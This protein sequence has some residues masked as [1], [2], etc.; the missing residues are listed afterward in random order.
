MTTTPRHTRRTALLAALL[1][2]CAYIHAQTTATPPG[3][4]EDEVVMLS[5]FEV[6][7][8]DA[9]GGYS[10]T[11]TLAGNRLN[12]DLRDVGS[13]VTVLTRQFFRDTGAVN[14][15]S[16][17]QYAPN[18]EVG[19]IS[20]N[21]AGAG[22]G[23]R[24]IEPIQR[25]NENTR[26]R[27]LAAADN[28]RDFFRTDIPWDSYNVDRVDLQRGPNSIL[29]GQGSP[30][31]IINAGTKGAGFRNSG[32][33]E[34][35][36]GSFGSNRVSLD[37]NQ[38]LV[39][40]Q[41]ALRVEALHDDQKFK[42]EPAYSK[43]QRLSGALRIEPELLK[44][45]GNRTIFKAS[46]ETGKIDSNNPRALPPTDNIT[47][48]FT[49]GSR[50]MN[51]QQLIGWNAWDHLSGRP[52]HGAARGA[53]DFPDP[54]LAGNSSPWFHNGNFGTSAGRE[55]V[56]FFSGSGA[57]TYWITD[58]QAELQGHGIGPSGAI[59]GDIGGFAVA[60][61]AMRSIA[62]TSTW[63][64]NSALPYSAGG[65]FKDNLITDPSIFDF[66]NKLI[67]GDTKREWQRFNTVTLNLTQTF[68]NDQAG[69]SLDYN[70]EHYQSGTVAMLGGNVG[71]FV[72]P[73]KVFDDGTPDVGANPGVEPFS[74]G[75]PNPGL[76]RPFV[77]S[78]GGV[79]NSYTSDRE[80][81]RATGFV[82]HDFARERKNWL[83]R[84]VG[85]QTLTG[86]LA[87]DNQKTDNRNWN[88]YGYMDQSVYD[89]EQ[90]SA[91]SNTFAQMTP[92]Q[93]VY[94]GGSLLGK[95]IGGANI[96][97]V[98]GN[99][100]IGNGQ[101]RYFNDHW[102][103]PTDPTAAGYVDPAAAWINN[104]YTSATP[105]RY[106]ST[107]SENPANY[108]GWTSAPLNVTDSESAAGNREKL[109]TLAAL[110]K[111]VTTSQ[112]LV[113]QGKM[114]DGSIV[115]TYGWRKDINKSWATTRRVG[116]AATITD[117]NGSTIP[118]PDYKRIDFNHYDLPSTPD[119][120]VEVQSR[121]YSI[122]GH[123]MDLPGLKERTKRL[124]FEVSLSY[125]VSSNFKPDS[126]RVDVEGNSIASPS[127][128]TI[129]RGIQIE[130]RDG[131]Y[132]LKI[133][134]YETSNK[135]AT[136][137]NSGAFGFGL[138]NFMGYNA[139][140]TNVWDYHIGNGFWDNK[141]PG[142]FE[143]GPEPRYLFRTAGTEISTP[144]TVADQ[145]SSVAG[146]RAFEA[147]VDK[148]LPNF[149]KAW[150]FTNL[151]YVQS[152]SPIPNAVN[153]DVR[154]PNGF[155]VTEDSV[156]KGWEIE[157]NAQPTRNWRL[158]F[159]AS[160]SEAVRSNIGGEALNKLM[161]VII[162]D[163]Q[164]PAGQLHY[165]WGTADVPRAGAA[166]YTQLQQTGVDWASRK[167]LEGTNVPELREWRANLISNYEITTGRLNGINFGGG[168]RYQS[169]VTIGY[170]PTGDPTK[171]ATYGYDLANAYKGPT[172]TNLDLWVG[173][174]RKLTAK[175]DWHIQLNVRNAFKGDDLIPISV[176]G[177]ISGQPPGTPA[178]YRI[179]PVQTFT[180]TN[181]FDF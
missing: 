12:T 70:K 85:G 104:A 148:A 111:S 10:A 73:M 1:L 46:F 149:W 36:Y 145:L 16:L 132:S 2:P 62:T 65:I 22:D 108:V 172:E 117:T 43:D 37:I 47:P 77:S 68:L 178:G 89:I 179:A 91:A 84:I 110:T 160:K 23:S 175:I 165:W 57:P 79:N 164:G 147:N 159:N 71:L 103:R 66:Y 153:G 127:G 169:D 21:Y 81:K 116:T 176:Q 130:T 53:A 41:V 39:P 158:T 137:T 19:G 69:F 18:S 154:V 32:E 25:P 60:P 140:W 20:G 173:Y 143:T 161:N 88:R 15:A 63:A 24:L 105:A 174:R 17:L 166:L 78:T 67:D 98:S 8:N 83:G 28:T 92:T 7:S 106:N 162:H 119:G 146:M 4:Q 101:L 74:N 75:T 113:W 136:G 170:P 13:A 141:T 48:W 131:K 177:P 55:P 150:G 30:A 126:S 58:V 76:G 9:A 40:S 168:V 99:P 125:N 133:N 151:A 102:N 50:G 54:S 97:N 134:R 129:D 61:G 38:V 87:E 107:Q 49:T 114:F 144:E 155:A 45:N 121:S 56:A 29:F 142:Y 152:G 3:T 112:A 72:D 120:R 14:N 11:T 94:L 123:L 27:G 31:G 100:T 82:T 96:P 64:V 59:D 124:P 35:R 122:V 157:L 115:G 52:G 95:S 51:Q 128:R 138:G 109:T 86:L 139:L 180:L 181:T 163:M 42:Q 44:K 167:L 5:P 26:I 171:P 118:N 90:L 33:V 6:T 34:A 93:I 80:S 135:N 156:S